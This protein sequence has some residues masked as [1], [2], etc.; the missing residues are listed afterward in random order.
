VRPL[1]VLIALVLGCSAVGYAIYR[2]I[3]GARL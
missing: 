2:L 3:E 1:P